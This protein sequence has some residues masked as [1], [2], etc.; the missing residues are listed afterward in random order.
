M[1][2]G[3]ARVAALLLRLPRGTPRPESGVPGSRLGSV[4]SLEKMGWR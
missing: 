3:G 4:L 1:N 2:P